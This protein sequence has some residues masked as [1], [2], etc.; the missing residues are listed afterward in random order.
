M[1][2]LPIQSKKIQKKLIQKEIKPQM[3]PEPTPLHDK[4]KLPPGTF[5]LKIQKKVHDKEGLDTIIPSE[6]L[7]QLAGAIAT[8]AATGGATVA[9]EALLTGGLSGLGSAITS[10]T[11]AGAIVGGGATSLASETLGNIGPVG[12]VLSG[13]IGGVAGRAAGRAVTNRMRNRNTNHTEELQPLLSSNTGERLGGRSDRN[14]LTE[15][16]VSHD[17]QTGNSST[18][19]L[20]PEQPP[21]TI[22]NRMAQNIRDRSQSI[23]DQVQNLRQQ[24]TGRIANASRGRYSRVAT[25][26]PIEQHE[27]MSASEPPIINVTDEIMPLLNRSATRIQRMN[28]ARRT[29]RIDN[30]DRLY[31]EQISRE[32]DENIARTR[33]EERQRDLE[34]VIGLDQILRQEQA[35][36]TNRNVAATRIQSAVRNKNALKETITKAQQKRDEINQSAA[37]TIQSALRNKN[38]IKETRTRGQQKAAAT[39]IQSAVR[40][41]NALNETIK[42]AQQKTE[43]AQKLRIQEIVDEQYKNQPIERAVVNDM[44]NQIAK[45]QE[46]F[47]KAG[48]KIQKVIRGHNTR[49]KLTDIMIESDM[50]KIIDKVNKT[51][52]KA[53]K[54]NKSASIIQKAVRKNR[55][56]T[57]STEPPRVST[58]QMTGIVAD[59]VSKNVVKNSFD[60]VKNIDRQK[61]INKMQ[62]DIMAHSI[63]Y[64]MSDN[65][66]NQAAL[67]QPAIIKIQSAV[68][69]RTAK[70]DMMNQRQQVGEAQLRQMEAVKD[71]AIKDDAA[72][73][74]Q[75]TAK[76]VLPQKDLKEVKQA[77]EKIGAVAKRLL[78]ERVSSTYSPAVNRTAIWNKNT[79]GQPLVVNKRLKLVSKKKHVAA[80]AGYENRQV[81]LDLA[82][83]YKSIMTKGKK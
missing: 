58:Q 8:G 6:R 31:Q 23:S 66:V 57:I 30:T 50:N 36:T 5:P 56:I 73:K 42:R 69:N 82:D 3:P 17:P 75:A 54:Y 47:Q 15:P 68:R 32:L 59:R 40:N 26:E 11:M 53:N 80:V 52:Q 21:Q 55:P 35:A 83:H 77:K 43:A 1:D 44:K 79:I 33:N 25:N 60:K 67:K 78:T 19:L 81:F 7:L 18:W 27:P 13:V 74:I 29:R 14:R 38:A 46:P 51:E 34:S 48:L 45:Q 64:D 72:K 16:Q 22:L 70:R 9:G 49:K 63:V 41:K 62:T 37:T 2:K 4:Y 10:G 65:A 28:R 24:I 20:P 61:A 12:H 39:R 71:N 76:K